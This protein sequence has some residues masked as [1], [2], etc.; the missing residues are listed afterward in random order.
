MEKKTKTQIIAL[1]KKSAEPVTVTL[2]PSKMR[3]GGV[4]NIGAA[5]LLKATEG[6]EIVHI[7]HN[8]PTDIQP[9]NDLLNSFSYYNCTAET[10]K[11]IHFYVGGKN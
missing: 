9:F 4:W 10:G 2:C 7:S 1:V 8:D 5:V 3:P 11:N 6:G